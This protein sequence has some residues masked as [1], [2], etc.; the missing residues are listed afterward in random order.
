M[1]E[2]E[3]RMNVARNKPNSLLRQFIRG[4]ACTFRS[5]NKLSNNA[6]YFNLFIARTVLFG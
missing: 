1:N 2:V 4:F 5:V 6:Y 3:Y